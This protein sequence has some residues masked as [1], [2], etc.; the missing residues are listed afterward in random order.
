M[1]HM[2]DSELPQPRPTE[3]DASDLYGEAA[4]V[5]RAAAELGIPVP[6]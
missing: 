6:F 1:T 3:P 2:D 5:A 4:W